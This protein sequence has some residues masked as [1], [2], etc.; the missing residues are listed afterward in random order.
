VKSSNF[1]KAYVGKRKFQTGREITVYIYRYDK[2]YEGAKFYDG[3]IVLQLSKNFE[4]GKQFWLDFIQVAEQRL[5]EDGIRSNG[6]AA[7]DKKIGNY[8]SYRNESFVPF[9][10]SLIAKLNA[11]EKLFYSKYQTV[12][13]R[14]YPPNYSGYNAGWHEDPLFPENNSWYIYAWYTYVY[15]SNKQYTQVKIA[16]FCNVSGH[17]VLHYGRSV[18]QILTL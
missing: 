10:P 6:L 12:G 18:R 1:Q 2:S 7:G 15:L 3:D 11:E 13:N 4:Q 14:V 5:Q 17:S 8:S 16:I 9:R